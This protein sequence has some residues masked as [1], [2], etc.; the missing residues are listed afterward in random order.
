MYLIDTHILL[1]FVNGDEK[2]PGS[3]KAILET[4]KTIF[5]SIATFWEIAIKN[6]IGKLNLP[7]SIA[8]LMEDCSQ[9]GFNILP[10]QASHLDRLKDLPWVHRDPFDRLLI[11]QAQEEKLTLITVDENIVKYEVQVFGKTEKGK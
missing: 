4:E 11:C 2:L 3:I 6:S 9:E 7:V 5:V 10:I 1:W 8:Q